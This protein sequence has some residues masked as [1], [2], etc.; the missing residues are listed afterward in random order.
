[1]SLSSLLLSPASRCH[2]CIKAHQPEETCF[3][4]QPLIRSYP[5]HNR[6]GAHSVLGRQCFSLPFKQA[7]VSVCLVQFQ[8]PF[9]DYSN[10]KFYVI[11]SCLFVIIMFSFEW[12][13]VIDFP[14]LYVTQILSNSVLIGNYRDQ[15]VSASP[16]GLGLIAPHSLRNG[17]YFLISFPLLP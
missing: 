2:N 10:K 4:C 15:Y 11:P 6:E 14:L 7:Y 13:N 17:F 9:Q 5:E 8:A 3:C 12:K 16:K 1:M